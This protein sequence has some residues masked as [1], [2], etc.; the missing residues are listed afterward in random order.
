MKQS[1]LWSSLSNH[2]SLVVMWWSCVSCRWNQ[3]FWLFKLNFTLKVRGQLPPQTIG[4]LAKVFCPSGANLVVLAGTGDE[5]WC[6]QAQ[7]GVNLKFQVKFDPEVQGRSFHKTIGIVT[8]VFYTSDP[9]LVILAW[10]KSRVIARTNKWYTHTRAQATAIS[11]GQNWPRVTMLTTCMMYD[12]S[13]AYTNPWGND[14]VTDAGR[15][16]HEAR[17]V[18]SCLQSGAV[19]TRPNITQYLIQQCSN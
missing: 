8:K 11:E 4:I 3:K 19:I 9:Y 16:M 13:P 1:G 18:N 7:N 6:G 2:S 10:A 14:K 12:W 15:V 17:L 5:L